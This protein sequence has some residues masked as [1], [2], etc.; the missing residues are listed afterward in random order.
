MILPEPMILSPRIPSGK[1]YHHMKIEDVDLS[2]IIPAFNEELRLGPSLDRILA[3]LRTRKLD[4]EILVADDGSRDATAVVARG[5]DDPPVRLV[6]L[7]ENRGK[8]AALRAGVAA[9]RGRRVLICDADLSTP[10]E[11]LALLEPY[12]ASTSVVFGS[13]AVADA[14]VT[15]RQPFYREFMGKVFNRLLFFFGIRGVRDT[16]CGFKLLDGAVARQLFEHLRTPGFAYDVE[17]LWLARHFG[18][19]VVEVGV[20]W[21]NSPSSRVNPLRDPPRM[22]WE[23]ARFRWLHRQLPPAGTDEP[24][25]R[26]DGS[27]GSAGA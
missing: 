3:H 24:D 4:F 11:D 16:Q 13:R 7:A 19:E 12:L 22:L 15:L 23:I 20:R 27:A 26:G 9:S 17:L 6:R 21:E 25:P 18:H 5:Y 8:G 10:I 14:R 2:V 1:F